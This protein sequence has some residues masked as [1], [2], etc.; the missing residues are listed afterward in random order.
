MTLFFQSSFGRLAYTDT[1]TGSPT[2]MLIHGLPTCKELFLPVLPHLKQDFRIINV[3]LNDYGESDKLSQF[4]SKKPGHGMTHKQ[5]ADILN[6]LRKHLGLESLILVAHDLGASVAMDYMGKYEQFIDKLVLMSPPVYPDFRE[7]RMVK[8]GRS[9]YI[10]EALTAVL[11]NFLMHNSISKG[12]VHKYNYTSDLRAAMIKPF[13]GKEGRAALH[14][15]LRWGRP[16]DF[17]ADYPAIMKKITTPTLIIH[18]QQDPYVPVGH[19][20]RLQKDIANAK[21]VIIEDGAHFLPI[22]TPEQVGQA[23]NNFLDF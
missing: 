12:L 1:E 4:T 22:D 13:A 20:Q 21:L 18:G 2:V 23:I 11:Q 9:P 5:R 6:D 17:F 15:N 16:A 10:G 3:D 8:I 14:R 7:P 19:A